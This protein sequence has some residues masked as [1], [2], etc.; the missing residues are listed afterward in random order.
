MANGLDTRFPPHATV[1][2]RPHMIDT[3]VSSLINPEDE[4]SYKRDF[5]EEGTERNR[6]GKKR[7]NH[8]KRGWMLA[9]E[10]E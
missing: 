3:A 1:E 8:K 6:Y 4:T 2:T 5:T 10:A 7:G 9:A